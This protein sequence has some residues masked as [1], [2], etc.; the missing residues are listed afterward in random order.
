MRNF[1][2]GPSPMLISSK[3]HLT[4]S[5]V[6]SHWKILS[7]ILWKC[8]GA[9]V[10]P[11]GMRVNS[12]TYKHLL[13]QKAV[14][15]IFSFLIETYQYSDFKSKVALNPATVASILGKG[16][17]CLIVFVFVGLKSTHP[18]KFPSDLV[19]LQNRELFL[20]Y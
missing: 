1:P 20:T 3:Y 19:L 16:Y 17:L 12:Y 7:I 13:A 8:A 5:R 9:L 6:Y 4:L 2:N 11:K 10:L 14:F 18:P 15:D